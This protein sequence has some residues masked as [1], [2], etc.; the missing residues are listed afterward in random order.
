MGITSFFSRFNA[1][2]AELKE[3]SSAT[4]DACV[5]EAL[6]QLAFDP[7]YTGGVYSLNSLDQCRIGKVKTVGSTVSFAVQATS[8]GSAV[9]NLKISA[10]VNDLSVLSWQETT[11]F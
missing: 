9:T 2:D 3:R 10:N 11:V 7:L 4:A 1:L 5:D 8:S 6:A